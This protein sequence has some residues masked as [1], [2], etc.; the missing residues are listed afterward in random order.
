MAYSATVVGHSA[1]GALWLPN[2]LVKV[3]DD[4]AQIKADLLIRRVMYNYSITGGS[5][6]TLHMTRKKAFTL[7]L[8]QSERDANTEETGDLFLV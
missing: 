8:E 4:F 7:E 1:N 6:T 5:L 3:T 2:E